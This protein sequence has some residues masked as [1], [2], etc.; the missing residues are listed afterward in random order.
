MGMAWHIDLSQ[1]NI[2]STMKIVS[3]ENFFKGSYIF[4][5]SL[6]NILLYGIIKRS[7]QV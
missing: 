6:Q 4:E 7:M 5:M 3:R 2:K 1:G